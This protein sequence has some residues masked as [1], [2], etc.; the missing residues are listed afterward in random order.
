MKLIPGTLLKAP[1]CKAYRLAGFL[2]FTLLASCSFVSNSLDYAE[3]YYQN[4]APFQVTQYN[5]KTDEKSQVKFKAFDNYKFKISTDEFYVKR[6]FA[7]SDL[8]LDRDHEYRE[9]EAKRSQNDYLTAQ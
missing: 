4:D 8:L 2:P 1:F 5:Y 6:T 7:F 3:D 9:S